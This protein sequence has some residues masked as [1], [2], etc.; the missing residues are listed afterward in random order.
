MLGH[1]CCARFDQRGFDHQRLTKR[2][3]A[4]LLRA[5]DDREKLLS[6]KL[7]AAHRQN[8]SRILRRHPSP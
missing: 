6:G 1:P 2:P 3:E 7:L 4:L 5:G 8:V